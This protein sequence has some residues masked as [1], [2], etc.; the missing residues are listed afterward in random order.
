[1]DADTDL[2]TVRDAAFGLDA[3]ALEARLASDARLQVASPLADEMRGILAYKQ[4]EMDEALPLLAK[5]ASSSVH[6]VH[7]NTLLFL[8]RG[9]FARGQ[10][11]AAVEHARA[12][13]ARDGDPAEAL[14][15]IGRVHLREKN[16]DAAEA[17]FAELAALAPDEP[18]VATQRMRIAAQRGDFEAQIRHADHLLSLTPDEPE[19]LRMAVDARV[20][21][22][23]FD[24]IDRLF[25]ALARIDPPGAQRRL[26]SLRGP[27][28]AV[29]KARTVRAL[30]AMEFHGGGGSE[31][32]SAADLAADQ[33]ALWLNAA[34]RLEA[35]HDDTRAAELLRAVR[36]LRPDDRDANEY[37]EQLV[38]GPL[39]VL[40]GA[41]RSRDEAAIVRAA[42]RVLRIDAELVEAWSALGRGAMKSDP[43]RAVAAFEQAIA[44]A[45]ND[46]FSRL[47]LGR[48]LMAAERFDEAITA[49][50]AVI[51]SCQD[52]DLAWREEAERSTASARRKLISQARAHLR[53]GRPRAAW[54]ALRASGHAGD[55][56][57]QS[58]ATA[59]P[60]A[61][62][63]AVRA[64]FAQS[65]PEWIAEAKAYLAAAPEDRTALL[66]LAREA[67]QRRQAGEALALWLRLNA[68]E[69]GQ[70]GHLVQI[71]RCHLMLKA[72]GA[73]A[74]AAGAALALD[75]DLADARRLAAEA[76]VAM[77]G[78][79]AA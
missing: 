52:S 25:P 47:N 30:M 8:M 33:A 24:G 53:E 6:Q 13:L 55:P 39:R 68:I 70:P 43:P 78:A 54:G 77:A 60:R 72:P 4:R 9:A 74:R 45:P 23:N 67:S 34:I 12:V 35:S 62:L 71:A 75:P 69:P 41:I 5:A 15:V 18:D 2:L 73:A 22:R 16:W 76:A 42:E 79:P 40:R 14:R 19:A 37:L 31:E 21:G 49:F 64:A 48:A 61:W 28:Q 3:E 17:A 1:M 59:I 10:S 29:I 36:I 57:C 51:A 63:K 20:R 58:L 44:L 26:T 32:L 66:L 65:D 38:D 46:P 56:E 50:E 27:D 11:A 7:R